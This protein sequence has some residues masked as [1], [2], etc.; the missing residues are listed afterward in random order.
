D[1]ADVVAVFRVVQEAVRRARAGHGPSLILCVMPEA[2][3]AQMVRKS[4]HDPLAFM[5]RYLRRRKLWSNEWQKKILDG[6]RKELDKAVASL[7]E[8]LPA[9]SAG[10]VKNAPA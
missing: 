8:P 4:T 7:K 5:E 6:F 9:W 1:G 3:S 2:S 10:P